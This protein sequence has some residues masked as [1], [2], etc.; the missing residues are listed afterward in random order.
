MIFY[1]CKNNGFLGGVLPAI[2]FLWI[3][4]DEA[5][6]PLKFWVFSY[7]FLGITMILVFTFSLEGVNYTRNMNND[8]LE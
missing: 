3:I 8:N 1:Y 6:P 7:I 2:L 5:D 4:I